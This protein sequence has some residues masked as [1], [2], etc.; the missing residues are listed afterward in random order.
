MGKGK[1]LDILAMERMGEA[2]EKELKEDGEY[3]DGLKEQENALREV[4]EM[5]LDED[6]EETVDRAVS[7]TNNCGTLY[8]IAAYRQGVRDGIRLIRELEEAA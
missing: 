5:M 6:Q 3:Q 2:L 7:A 4:K 8:G 1:L